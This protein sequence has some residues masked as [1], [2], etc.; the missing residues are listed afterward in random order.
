MASGPSPFEIHDFN[1]MKTQSLKQFKEA[2]SEGRLQDAERVAM[3]SH[4]ESPDEWNPIY[5]LGLVCREK[6]D[7]KGALS[8]Y[9]E[10]LQLTS[11]Q[12]SESAA[13]LRAC[14]IA[15]QL[16]GE[17]DKALDVFGDSLRADPESVVGLNSLGITYR[18][19]GKYQHALYYYCIALNLCFKAAWAEVKGKG[20][21]RD[22]LDN[23]SNK[24]LLLAGESF[25]AYRDAILGSPYINLIENVGAAFE[26]MGDTERAQ[27]FF[28]TA[29]SKNPVDED[30]IWKI[31]KNAKKVV[32]IAPKSNHD[33]NARDQ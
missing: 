3:L 14:G 4:G 23:N 20:L 22:V 25:E 31:F 30:V 7:F 29:E 21:I 8:R 24:G 11:K 9:H 32:E 33:S 10:A 5:C 13:I 2:L 27:Y 17:Y 19:M 1:K 16:L 28:R 12:S 15:H 18:K 6:G 26:A